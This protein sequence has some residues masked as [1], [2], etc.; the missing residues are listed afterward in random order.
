M[1]LLSMV[2]TVVVCRNP[3]RNPPTHDANMNHVSKRQLVYKFMDLPWVIQRQIAHELTV[4]HYNEEFEVDNNFR[5][6]FFERLSQKGLVEALKK[7]LFPD[8]EPQPATHPCA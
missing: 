7:R 4:I 1:G 5:H 8:Y 2:P 3:S 6:A